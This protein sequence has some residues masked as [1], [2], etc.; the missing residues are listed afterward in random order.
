MSAQVERAPEGRGAE[1]WA[2]AFREDCAHVA[3]LLGAPGRA[4]LAG[5]RWFGRPVLEVASSRA[6]QEELIASS[7]VHQ[8]AHGFGRIGWKPA[9]ELRAGE[10]TPSVWHL[11]DLPTRPWFEPDAIDRRLEAAHAEIL[12]DFTGIRETMQPHPDSGEIVSRGAWPAIIVIG[13]GGEAPGL[14]ARLPHLMPLIDALPVC[15]NFGF[16]FF[17]GTV[18]GTSIDAHSGST[19]LRLRRHLALAVAEDTDAA[20]TVDGVSRPW[21]A[22]RCMAFDDAYAH[23][24]EHRSGGDRVILSVDTWHPALDEEEVAVLSDPVFPRFGK[25][26]RSLDAPD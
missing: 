11:P 18:A 22:G 4:R 19:N 25:I 5:L 16:V 2:E 8:D 17:A 14:R 24:V 26:T 20:M 6:L 12:A 7:G 23:S 10:V 21:I 3:R 15:G 1:G 13:A 9:P